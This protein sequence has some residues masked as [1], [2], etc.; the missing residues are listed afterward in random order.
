MLSDST[1]DIALS[2]SKSL[3]EEVFKDLFALTDLNNDGYVTLFEYYLQETKPSKLL[4]VDPV[5]KD[6]VR[7]LFQ[8][9]QNTE[10]NTSLNYRQ[11]IDFHC[12]FGVAVSRA[13]YE[14]FDIDGNGIVAGRELRLFEPEAAK[15]RRD[16]TPF[17][18]QLILELRY[19]Y[20]DF[21][22]YPNDF[23]LN[24]LTA[25]NVAIYGLI[26][27]KLELETIRNGFVE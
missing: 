6:W 26:L 4:N 13:M 14:P 22:N 9:L 2:V 10:Y 18:R 16:M 5:E 15:I 21:L 7:V 11:F 27:S 3:K 17:G 25:K 24:R 19:R 8:Q 12:K 20:T 23:S 1:A